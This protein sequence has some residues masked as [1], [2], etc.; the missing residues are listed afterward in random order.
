[1]TNATEVDDI[2]V[3]PISPGGMGGEPVAI[4]TKDGKVVRI[5]P[6]RWDMNYTANELKSRLWQFESKGRVFKAPMKTIPSYF[7]LSYKKRAYSKNRVLYPL[8]R[9]DWEPGGNPDKI[10]PQNRGKSKFERITW[11]EAYDIILSEVR[12]VKEKYGPYTVM[13]VGEDG[14]KE[15]KILHGAG[16]WHAHLLSHMGG[17]TREIRSPDSIEGF[18]WGAK[19]VWG[20]GAQGIGVAAPCANVVKDVT[21]NC[22]L[23]VLQSGDLETTQNFHSQFWSHLIRGWLDIG[24]KMVSID[25]F[26]TYTNVIH[27]N[28]KWIPILPNTDA[29]LDFALMYVWITEDLYKKDYVATHVTGFDKL[30]AYVLGEEDG[31]PKTPE[32]AAPLCGVPVWTIKALA[33]DWGT[34]RTTITHFCGCHSRGVYSHEPGRTEA[35]KLGMQ[36]LGGPGVHQLHMWAFYTA[37]QKMKNMAGELFMQAAMRILMFVPTV[38]QIPRTMTHWAIDKGHIEH[39]GSTQIIMEPTEDQF[40]KY[41]FP[42]PADQ[43]G[44]EIHMLWSEKPCNMGCWNGGFYYQEQMRNPKIECIITN[45]QWL[46][47]DSLFADIILPITSVLEEADCMGSG[48]NSTVDIAGIQRKAIEPQGESKSDYEIAVD[49]ARRIGVE[50]EITA[51]L[52]VDEW[53][54]YSYDMSDLGDEIEY[55]ELVEKQ[56]YI[57][58]LEPD[59]QDIPPGMRLFY[60]DPEAN[61]LETPSGKLEFYSEGIAQYFPDDQERGPLAKWVEGGPASEGWTH[62]ERLGGE[63]SKKYPFLLV[64][65]PGRRRMH[66]QGDDVTWFREIPTCKVR[67]SDGYL[68]EPVWICPEDAEKYGIQDG[69]IVKVFNEE[70]IVLAGAR[71][72]ERVLPNAIVINKGARVDPI[73][74]RIDRGG[75]TNLI[76]PPGPLS[77][78]C[79]GFA[80]SGFLVGIEKL[81]DQ[82]M[83]GW[84]QEYPEAFARAYDP[85]TGCHYDSWVVGEG[86]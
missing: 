48:F 74:P 32:W 13:A 64:A 10:N 29:A 60:D 33:R 78:N 35:Y 83:D 31:I 49:L 45:H 69:D 17:Y 65:S 73:G 6:M 12:R 28:M 38:Q 63:R 56:Y 80:V 75:S 43:G 14:H 39:W 55:A 2:V 23:L 70:G 9:V 84:K 62:D 37:K 15:S 79:W 19:H 20:F 4:D 52:S 22:E 85:A 54:E 50:D 68:Y 3:R 40:V 46:E 44:S 81:S 24:M 25:P 26:C 7:A 5:R 18:Y 30:K 11:D 66:V 58:E 51:G 41:E 71:I 53:L 72:S 82:E 59:W 21:D 67:A 61:P 42:A 8:K 16:G 77:K 76:S 1:M 86:E 57:P 36:G 47:N 34:K 27:D